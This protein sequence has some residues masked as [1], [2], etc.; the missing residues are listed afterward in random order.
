MQQ[1]LQTTEMHGA[2]SGLTPALFI[3][4]LPV[5]RWQ[6]VGD[7]V[8]AWFRC[9]DLR[10]V[11][12]PDREV[13]PLFDEGNLFQ[14]RI[15][16][17]S[18]GTTAVLTAVISV[19]DIVRRF[20]V[21]NSLNEFYYGQPL[22]PWIDSAGS[23]AAF[24]AANPDVFR[25]Q[26]V[27]PLGIIHSPDLL[28]KVFAPD[29]KDPFSG[30]TG[31]PMRT[32]NYSTL[33][34]RD[35]QSPV[36]GPLYCETP[37]IVDSH[38]FLGPV[39][40]AS[41]FYRR[42]TARPRVMQ[43]QTVIALPSSRRVQ[44]ATNQ[45]EG[46]LPKEV[47]VDR[48]SI[49]SVPF[50]RPW[51]P[52]FSFLRDLARRRGIYVDAAGIATRRGQP[53]KG[54]FHPGELEMFSDTYSIGNS[55][56]THQDAGK[57]EFI[58]LSTS[59]RFGGVN[60]IDSQALDGVTLLFSERS[61]MIRGDIGG[62]LMVV[63]PKHIFITGPTNPE[64]TFDLMLVGGLGVAIS[65]ADLE[66]F[67]EAKQVDD[68]YVDAARQWI[69][70]AVMYKPGAGMFRRAGRPLE[71]EPQFSSRGLFRGRSLALTIQ[72]A[73]LEGN[74]QRWMDASSAD[75]FLITWDA[76]MGRSLPQKPVSVNLFRLR[77]EVGP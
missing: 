30:V 5:D 31:Q 41:Y 54:D 61:V 50:L 27:T 3:P 7:R 39:Q 4:R 9:S 8:D 57:Q 73:C 36:Q 2:V 72:G 1:T 15:E 44:L 26:E 35:G 29:G 42:G 17:R 32:G 18:E 63:T 53:L 40:T 52:D 71:N 11:S 37:I 58:V 14:V 60:N 55:P 48:D 70:R 19:T 66:E 69:V 23:L 47:C 64:G 38:T 77:A 28:V 67:L 68:A 43:D 16:G 13:T 34:Q 49:G 46:E 33:Y 21:M 65:T 6:R 76:R 74:L 10:K 62:D 22:R 20:A 56:K 25:R 45:L 51:R 59:Q 12:V 24:S 75:E